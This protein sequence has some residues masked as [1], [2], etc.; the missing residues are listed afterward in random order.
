MPLPSSLVGQ[1]SSHE[2]DLDARWAMAYVAAL[3]D[4]H[5]AYFDTTAGPLL[6]HPMLTSGAE[7]PALVAA[8][9]A[10]GLSEEERRLGVHTSH[11]LVLDAPLYTQGPITVRASVD[12]VAQLR[13]GAHQVTRL[14][15]VD[16]EGRRLWTT[17]HGTIFRG[18]AVAGED[19]PPAHDP[20]ALPELPVGDPAHELV[21]PVA[22]GA[23]H[24]Y[25]E[26]A[27]IWN[28]IHTD[29]AVARAAGLP[30]PILHG[31]H[32][33]ALALSRL[34]AALDVDPARV[35]RVA[36]RLHAPVLMPS[37]IRVRVWA[38]EP[39]RFEVAAGA[40]LAIRSGLVELE[41]K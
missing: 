23:A 26:C 14:E 5:A 6:V 12:G 19:R 3:G 1:G 41:K 28:P 18:V 38:G 34:L 16:A 36:C 11:E 8:R 22:M 13:P 24:V 33:I 32:T 37:E 35:R 21:V 17:W 4:S 29:V 9:D 20:S 40:G 15:A 2:C 10:A 30:G 7:W 27:R 25:T 31:T 39:I